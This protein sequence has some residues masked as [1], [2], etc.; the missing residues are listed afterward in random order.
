LD[1]SIGFIH[2]IFSLNGI[3]QNEIFK[4]DCQKL[5]AANPGAKSKGHHKYPL[6]PR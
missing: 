4:T 6:P 3:S 2:E 5:E 1:N